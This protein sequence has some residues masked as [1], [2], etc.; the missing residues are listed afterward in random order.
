[1]QRLT[2]QPTACSW[3]FW[4]LARLQKAGLPVVAS[5]ESYRNMY[6][7]SVSLCVQHCPKT[8]AHDN[9]K[10]GKKQ[11]MNV[12]KMEELVFTSDGVGVLS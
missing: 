9:L 12:E 5:M 4:R 1:M 11:A 2:D 8:E 6:L 10:K 7:M 3:W